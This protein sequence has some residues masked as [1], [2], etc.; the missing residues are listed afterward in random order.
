[1]DGPQTSG[2]TGPVTVAIDDYVAAVD[3]GLRG[4]A[5]LR[6]DM[7]AEIRDALVDAAESHQRA[8]LGTPEAQ[9][10]A[11]QEFGSA[12]RIAAGLQD[13]LAVTQARRTALLL[14]VVL[15]IQHG[16]TD[17]I[18]RV[19]GWRQFWGTTQ[20]GEAYLWLARATDL[21]GGF[22]LTVV[23]AVV[24][25]LHWRQRRIG[26]DR[27][28]VRLTAVLTSVVI[29]TTLVCGVLL[30]VLPPN[31]G[32]VE[33]LVGGLG[34]LTASAV[35]LGSAWHCWHAASRPDSRPARQPVE[36]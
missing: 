1:M 27:M 9:Q 17:L 8:G 25:L 18:G 4:S 20:P 35:V 24:V 31:T 22:A 15:G 32:G 6:A 13:V 7:L 14:L 16:T 23:V 36:S 30:S 19:G 34:S 28:V 10:L 21:F 11:V 29:A 3:S 2:E 5:R 26:I 12:R 33:L